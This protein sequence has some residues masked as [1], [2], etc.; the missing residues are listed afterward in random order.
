MHAAHN[1][2]KSS[3]GNCNGDNNAAQCKSHHFSKSNCDKDWK[4]VEV[5]AANAFAEKR[6]TY[7]SRQRTT[8]IEVTRINDSFNDR[9]E[10]AESTMKRKRRNTVDKFNWHFVWDALRSVSLT[11]LSTQ[12]QLAIQ[13]ESMYYRALQPEKLQ[14]TH[15]FTRTS[16]SSCSYKYYVVESLCIIR[17]SNELLHRTKNKYQRQR[18]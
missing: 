13:E 15:T 12:T 10:R 17:I 1:N 14:Y 3:N 11:F 2:V 4:S 9:W 8:Y 5:N 18:Q 7:V 16:T 6:E